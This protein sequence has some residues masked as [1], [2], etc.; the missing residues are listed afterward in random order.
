MPNLSVIAAELEQDIRSHRLLDLPTPYP[1]DFVFPSYNGL[2]IFN[3]MQSVGALLGADMPYGLDARLLS[4]IPQDVDRVVVLITDGLGYY[5]LRHLI[6]QEPGLRDDVEAITEKGGFV[7]LTSSAPSTTACALPVF[8]TAEPPAITGMLGTSMFLPKVGVLTDMLS[9]RAF[10]P[11]Q[12]AQ[13]EAANLQPEQF[14]PVPSVPQ[15]LA[16]AGVPTHLL[17]MRSLYNTGLSRFMHRGV[18]HMHP[19]LGLND[20]WMR[21]HDMLSETR[22]QKCYINVYV[23][24]VDSL[25]H[26]YGADAPYVNAEIVYQFQQLRRLLQDPA[27]HDGRTLFMITADHGHQNT[28][29]TIDLRVDPRFAPVRDAMHGYGG[30]ERFLYLYVR[31][32]MCEPL[33]AYLTHDLSDVVTAV[34]RETALQAGLFGD[35]ARAAEWHPEIRERVGDILIFARPGVRFT[36]SHSQ[37]RMPPMVS[38]HAGLSPAEMLVPLVWRRF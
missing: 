15:R 26:A 12:K 27:L 30:D 16:E 11:A 13:F 9:F 28:P 17:L 34:D 1:A 5:R 38:I 6:E 37:Y 33:L 20:L 18:Q 3:L 36:D 35:T 25:S 29:H 2:S 32:G 8:W 24:N 31:D 23:P 22:G 10:D 4:Q 19:H 14:V 7:P 21:L